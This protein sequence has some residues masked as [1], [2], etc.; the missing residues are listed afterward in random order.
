[1]SAAE[2]FADKLLQHSMCTC[3]GNYNDHKTNCEYM[4]WKSTLPP[5][6]SLPD[7]RQK[8]KEGD[9]L[10]YGRPLDEMDD[11]YL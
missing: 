2:V 3:N 7:I 8:I 1:M 10:L 11:D 4:V 6:E 5:K 9:I